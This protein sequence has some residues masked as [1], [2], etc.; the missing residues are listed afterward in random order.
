MKL[1]NQGEIAQRYLRSDADRQ[2]VG[3]WT[4]VDFSALSEDLPS[5]E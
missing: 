2:G 4:A 5:A 3:I 1:W